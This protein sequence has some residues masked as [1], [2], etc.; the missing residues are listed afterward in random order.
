MSEAFERPKVPWREYF[1]SECSKFIWAKNKK[2]P[3]IQ[4]VVSGDSLAY[5]INTTVYA[6]VL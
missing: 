1:G 3:S 5:L 2:Y 4:D 6:A